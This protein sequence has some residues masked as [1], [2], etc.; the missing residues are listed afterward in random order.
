MTSS[1]ADAPDL[2]FVVPCKGRLEHLKASLPAM[3]AQASSRVVVVDSNCPDG[4]GAWVA[5]A[6]PDV[7]VVRL[8]DGGKFN[9]SRCRNAGLQAAATPW[10]CFIDAD[11]VVAECFSRELTPRLAPGAFYL[12]DNFPGRTDLTGTCVVAREAAMAIGGYDEVFEAWGGRDRDFY[13]R[14]HLAGCTAMAMPN[15]M[16]TEIFS[17][18]DESRTTFYARKDIQLSQSI[19]AVYRLAKVHF[20][21][22]GGPGFL[23]LADRRDLYAKAQAAV[24]LAVDSGAKSA[25]LLL[26]LPVEGQFVPAAGALRQTLAIEIDTSG[27]RRR[28]PDLARV[29]PGPA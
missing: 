29:D 21:N 14:L 13:M 25:R 3:V 27:V 7:E 4:A 23:T 17:H 11:V 15:A 12:F 5:L 20:I 10:I 26:D 22:H 16:I 6:Y 2:T 24:M 8:D 1:G 28:P 19:S 18:S 9:L